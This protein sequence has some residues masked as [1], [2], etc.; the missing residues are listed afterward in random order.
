MPDDSKVIQ[1]WAIPP[2]DSEHVLCEEFRYHRFEFAVKLISSL[3]QA[4]FRHSFWKVAEYE[5][6]EED[7]N[8]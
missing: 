6:E 2:G 8:E 1:V 3:K 4:G 7:E 5:D